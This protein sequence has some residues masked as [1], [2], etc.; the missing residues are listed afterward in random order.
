MLHGYIKVAS[1]TPEMRV[2]D[3]D[4]NGDKI[5][6]AMKQC[7]TEE[8]KIAVFPELSITGYSCGDLFLQD[9]LLSE[10]MMTLKRI[11]EASRELDLFLFVGL[12]VVVN[13][14]VYNGAAAIKDGRLLGVVPKKNGP[15]YT[16]HYELR[17]FSM[18][19]DE[20]EVVDFGFGLGK[21]PFGTKILF[22]CENLPK[23][24]IAVEICEDLWVPIPESNHHAIAGATIIANLSASAEVTGKHIYR[25]SLVKGQSAR[26]M[27]GY[28]YTSSG[29]GESSTDIVYGGHDL[30]CENGEILVEKPLFEDGMITAEIDLEKLLHDRRRVNTFGTVNTDNYQKVKFSYQKLTP[31]VRLLRKIPKSPFIPSDREE[32]K[33][34]SQE[35]ITIQTMGLRKRL[36]H[37]HGNSAI[38]GVSGGLDSTLALLITYKTFN[39]LGL[40][41][42]GIVAVTMPCFGTTGRTYQNAVLLAKKLG[43]TL[44]E[45]NI[46]EAV[47]LHLKDIGH[48]INVHDVTFENAQARERTQV[49]MDIANSRG[50][51]VIGTGD[52]SEMALGWATYNGDHMSM[53]GVNASVPKTMVRF[54]VMYF[55]EL[56]EEGG[57]E[58]LSEVLYDILDTPVSPELLPPDEN[59]KIKQRTEDIVGPY[60]LHDFFLY[61]MLRWG[62]SPDKIYRLACT[63]F[64]DEFEKDFIHKWL[65]TFY[66]RFFISQYK[67]SCVPDGVRVGSIGLSPRG[68]FRMPSDAMVNSW[69][70]IIDEIAPKN[71][72]EN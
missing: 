67:R 1:I 59:G 44:L 63:A 19:L 7:A 54:L 65:K 8:V 2:A 20:S 12:P 18:A 42:K 64:H 39:L 30:I 62:F 36:H 17:T 56:A 47:T 40:D 13:G 58:E 22:E 57:E 33:R 26:L 70:K 21:A 25:R 29:N 46:K 51:I 24:K 45:I 16:E 48:D 35:V 4:F 6:E 69:M 27:A 53:Y 37:I 32:R 41:R 60:E 61:Y 52:M 15:N 9:R 11:V 10:A 50:G 23:L 72:N 66:H 68:D 5:I 43:V 38:I 28:I 71:N 14:K 55:A 34:V 3:C 49:L 31:M